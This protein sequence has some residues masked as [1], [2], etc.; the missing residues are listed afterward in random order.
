MLVATCEKYPNTRTKDVETMEIGQASIL[1]GGGCSSPVLT[2]NAG[3]LLKS[4]MPLAWNM[5]AC[6]DMQKFQEQKSRAT[7]WHSTLW[8]FLMLLYKMLIEVSAALGVA[9]WVMRAE[10]VNLPLK[11]CRPF[12][13]CYSDTS[14]L[15][16]VS[17][18]GHDAGKCEVPNGCTPKCTSKEGTMDGA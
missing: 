7:G 12:V 4:E 6:V 11:T 9:G 13:S 8:L 1:T 16:P 15:S 5:C 2:Q 3:H 14:A 10:P 17:A 18:C